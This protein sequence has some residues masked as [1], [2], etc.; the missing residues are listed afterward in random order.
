MLAGD[1]EQGVADTVAEECGV[2]NANAA[3]PS[4][5]QQGSQPCIGGQNRTKGRPSL[6]LEHP[7]LADL[8]ILLDDAHAVEVSWLATREFQPHCTLT[9]TKCLRAVLESGYIT[10]KGVLVDVPHNRSSHPLWAR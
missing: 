10:K 9:H 2:T 3:T 8:S 7:V 1:G 6:S 5:V 4:A